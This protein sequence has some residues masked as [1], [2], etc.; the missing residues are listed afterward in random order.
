MEVPV[1]GLLVD[2][3]R[4]GGWRGRR[5]HPYFPGGLTGPRPSCGSQRALGTNTAENLRLWR[6]RRNERGGV[7]AEGPSWLAFCK[8]FY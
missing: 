1:P 2:R 3:L 4:P 5:R 6:A 7:T 8:T